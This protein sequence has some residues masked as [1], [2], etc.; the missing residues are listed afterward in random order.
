[1]HK[2]LRGEI[3]KTV[4]NVKHRVAGNTSEFNSSHNCSCLFIVKF[5]QTILLLLVSIT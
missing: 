3:H 1:M 5:T 4:L 2:L